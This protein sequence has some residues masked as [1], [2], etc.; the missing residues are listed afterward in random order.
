MEA[1]GFENVVG[2]VYKWP[3]N[4]CPRDKK[5]KEL[6]MWSL[7]NMDQ[8]LEPAT[9]VPLAR[10]LGYTHEVLVL[11]SKTWKV[12]RDTS[13]CYWP[14][15]AVYGRKSLSAPVNITDPGSSLDSGTGG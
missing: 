5:H 12:L 10:A 14:I 3:T 6:G 1:A 9:V 11:V 7:A 4:R 15:H 8:A 2:V 13:V